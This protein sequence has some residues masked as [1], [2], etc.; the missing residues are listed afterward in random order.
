MKHFI[1]SALLIAAVVTAQEYHV[2]RRAENLVKFTSDAPMEK[3]VGTTKAIDGYVL[4]QPIDGKQSGEFYFEVDLATL[5]TGI[6]LRNRHMR[7]NYLETKRYPFAV[8]KGRIIE[9]EETADGYRVK[10]QG[11]F[12]LHGV[13][14]ELTIDGRVTT[15]DKGYRAESRFEI[16]LADFKI[17]RPQLM[18][19]KVGE[20]VQVEVVF[21]VVPAK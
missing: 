12:D 4:L 14:K 11:I 10:T 20:V 8:Y 15:T 5:D 3:I 18:L 7:D 13:Q 21:Y 2:D 9:A 17:E 16:A 6:G 19:L 1:F